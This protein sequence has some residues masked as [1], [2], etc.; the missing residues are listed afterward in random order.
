MWRWTLLC[1]TVAAGLLPFTLSC[2]CCE[3]NATLSEC[4][5][6]AE[7][8]SRPDCKCCLAC[9]RLLGERRRWIMCR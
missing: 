8:R 6:G 1:V 5:P 7:L 9:G 4:G 2:G 3:K